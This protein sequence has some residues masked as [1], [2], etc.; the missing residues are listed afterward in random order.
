[1][2][3]VLLLL[4]MICMVVGIWWLFGFGVGM[5]AAGMALISVAVI[6]D[7]NKGR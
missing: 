6:I 4:G 3:T 5:I 2:Q 1:M 7:F